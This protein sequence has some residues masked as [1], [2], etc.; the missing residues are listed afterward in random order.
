MNKQD[1]ERF[2]NSTIEEPRKNY[3]KNLMIFSVPFIGSIL[4]IFL[5]L[6]LKSIPYDKAIEYFK[7]G[8]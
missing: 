2:K 4:M 8:N 1:W 6:K 3:L 5:V 7:G